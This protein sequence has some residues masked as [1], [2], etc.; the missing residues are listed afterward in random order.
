MF[1]KI[2]YIFSSALVIAMLTIGTV[3]ISAN[4]GTQPNPLVKEQ[5]ARG[6][7][8]KRLLSIRSADKLEGILARL[9]ASDKIS[10]EQAAKLK[11]FWVK[12][13][14]QMAKGQALKRIM[15]IQDKAK[16]NEFL[17]QLTANN[18]ITQEQAAKIR[19]LWEKRHNQ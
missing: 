14:V 7:L 15:R 1:K 16:L 4:D 2:V 13:H 19:E 3:A 10:L 6:Q 8:L 12:H 18:R 5:V 9:V 17:A 11:D